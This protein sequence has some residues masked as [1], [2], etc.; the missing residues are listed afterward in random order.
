MQQVCVTE[1]NENGCVGPEVCLDV[2]VED[3]VAQ[4]A[5]V[6]ATSSL[7]AYPNPVQESL[8][9]QCE[10]CKAGE[11]MQV[12]NSVGAVM[13]TSIWEGS[14]RQSLD[15]RSLPAGLHMLQVG[16][17]TTPFIVK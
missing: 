16:A 10:A 5:Q 12:W 2:W 13:Q 11:K 14:P 15:V 4:V 7:L 1:T 9:V 6:L 17:A 3:D 8:M